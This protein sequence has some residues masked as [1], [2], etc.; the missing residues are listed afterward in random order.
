MRKVILY[1]P[2]CVLEGYMNDKGEFADH[3]GVL[4]TMV[5]EPTTIKMANEDI[6]DIE[7]TSRQF[8]S[9]DKDKLLKIMQAD[10]G[11][12]Q[13]Q[14]GHLHDVGEIVKT[15]AGKLEA[16]P[17]EEEEGETEDGWIDME[18]SDD[19]KE[20]FAGLLEQYAH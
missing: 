5:T 12:Q 11:I 13:V 16:P 18:L 15:K 17:E 20:Y 10:K 6:P 19:D 3:D 9:A 8:I 4:L 14:I 1:Y 2:N 7:F